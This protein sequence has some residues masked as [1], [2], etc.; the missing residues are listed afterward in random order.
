MSKTSLGLIKAISRSRKPWRAQVEISHA[1]G[2][3]SPRRG[4]KVIEAVEG[5]E[6]VTADCTAIESDGCELRYAFFVEP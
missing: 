3:R 2:T 1:V 4:R 5:N 6:K